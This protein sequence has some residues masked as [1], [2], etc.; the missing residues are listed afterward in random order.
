MWRRDRVIFHFYIFWSVGHPT[1]YCDELISTICNYKKESYFSLYSFWSVGHINY[2]KFSLFTIYFDEL[3]S[4][5]EI[6]IFH[7]YSFWSVTKKMCLFTIYCDELISTICDDETESYF[8]LL[9]ILVCRPHKLQKCVY[10]LF[11]MMNL[12]QQYVT[13]RESY[14]SLL[15]TLVCRSNKLHQI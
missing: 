10:L 5:I 4:I 12:F 9:H 1:I 7:F 15:Q 2:N 14:F 11:I 6:V 3:I 8:S 13:T